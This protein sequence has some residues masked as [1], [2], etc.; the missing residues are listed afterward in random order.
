MK[1]ISQLFFV[2]ALFAVL[3]TPVHTVLI[4]SALAAEEPATEE[5]TTEEP[6]KKKKKAEEEPDC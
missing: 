3:M 2:F 5:S 4:D 1:N 6:E